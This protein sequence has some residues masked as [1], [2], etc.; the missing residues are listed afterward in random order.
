MD[1]Q[2]DYQHRKEELETLPIEGLSIFVLTHEDKPFN[3]EVSISF[4][5]DEAIAELNKR[6][7]GKEGPTDVLSFECD[8]PDDDLS[9]MLGVEEAVL[10]LGDVVIAP[11]VA[12]R[13]TAEFSTTFEEE[14]SL[15]LVHGL[16]HLCGYDHV[17]DDDAEKM[18]S[19]EA[20]IL[21][22]WTARK[23]AQ[24][25]TTTEGGQPVQ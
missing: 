25:V 8:D 1:I 21:E 9:A 15:L 22:E 11:D 6:Y 13:Q 17:E 4:V 20:E 10:T 19:L 24:S 14:I 23:T 16:L 2:I 12:I 3:T 5:T 18:E 7:R